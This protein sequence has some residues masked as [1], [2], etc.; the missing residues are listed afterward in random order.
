[1][2][3]SGLEVDLVASKGDALACVEVKSGWVARLEGTLERDLRWRPL[4]RVDRSRERRLARAARELAA[5]ARRP[6]PVALLAEVRIDR[7]CRRPDLR[8]LWSERGTRLPAC[9]PACAPGQSRPR[10]PADS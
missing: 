2:R 7:E 10:R 6:R 8:L 1:V 3:T 5:L 4:S 9:G